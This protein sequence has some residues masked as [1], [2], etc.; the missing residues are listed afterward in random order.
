MIK[1]LENALKSRQPAGRNF[2]YASMP[3]MLHNWVF[4]LQYTGITLHVEFLWVNF[5][6]CVYQLRHQI[7][8]EKI[9]WISNTQCKADAN[10]V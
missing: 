4:Y 1:I 10:L 6:W 2:N 3:V 7:K 5:T 8:L 9:P